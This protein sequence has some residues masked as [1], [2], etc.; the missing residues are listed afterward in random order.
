MRYSEIIRTVAYC[1]IWVVVSV[2]CK[3]ETP[4]ATGKKVFPW[5]VYKDWN[6][7]KDIEPVK[8]IISS[9]S[10]FGNPPKSLIPSV[11]SEIPRNLLLTSVTGIISKSIRL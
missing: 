8:E 10:V 2:S 3:Q 7:F 1:A 9:I 5:F 6:S 4:T 11:F